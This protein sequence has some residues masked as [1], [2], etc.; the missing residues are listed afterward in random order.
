VAGWLAAADLHL[1]QRAGQEIF[2]NL[3]AEEESELALAQ[4][5]SLRAF[6]FPIHVDEKLIEVNSMRQALLRMRK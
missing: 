5:G 6:G 1:R 3:E 2:R 4:A